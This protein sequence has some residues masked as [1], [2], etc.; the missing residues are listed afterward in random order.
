MVVLLA[1][2]CN[3]TPAHEK[4]PFNGSVVAV[5]IKTLREDVPRFYSMEFDGRRI[6]FFLI[7]VNG[8][9]QSYFDACAMCYRERLAIAWKEKISSAGPAT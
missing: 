4:A 9:V 5:D 3:K 1:V 7:K 2:S 6:N 8:D